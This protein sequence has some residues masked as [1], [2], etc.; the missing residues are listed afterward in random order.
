MALGPEQLRIGVVILAAGASVRMGRPKLLLP[1]GGTSVLGHLLAQWRKL[2][3]QQI[4]VVLARDDATL[5]RE[6]AALQAHDVF[7][8]MNDDPTR[9]MFSSVQVAAAWTGWSPA[10]THWLISLG[11]QPQVRMETFAHLLAEAAKHPEWI[12]QPAR[13]GRAR[14]PIVLPAAPFRLL[15][16][17][18]EENLKQFLAARGDTRHV[19][20][21]EDPG[22]DLDL[23]Y[24]E[25]YER[26]RQN[27]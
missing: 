21:S 1:W 15:A 2:Q 25:D 17:A 10:I 18:E 24:P 16:M 6:L 12:C 22:L 27:M 8:L 14:H 9:G 13:N 20:E 26:A 3:P 5:P 7:Q 23:D 19:F 11:D 4:A